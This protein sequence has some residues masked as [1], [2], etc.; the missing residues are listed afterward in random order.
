MIPYEYLFQTDYY[1]DQVVFP[2]VESFNAK[3]IFNRMKFST[4][5][6]HKDIFEIENSQAITQV[7]NYCWQ[8]QI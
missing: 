6:L 3:F 4:L 5:M 1:K 8:S 2:M 7:K